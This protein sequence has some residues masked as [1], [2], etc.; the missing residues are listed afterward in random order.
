M[1]VVHCSSPH[2]NQGSRH[3]HDCT[4]W[5]SCG[6]DDES[7]T[8]YRI[9]LWQKAL[10]MPPHADGLSGSRW[11]KVKT[12]PFTHAPSNLCVCWL[13]NF[14]LFAQ[15]LSRAAFMVSRY[16]IWRFLW[17]TLRHVLLSTKKCFECIK[18]SA[19]IQ[20]YIYAKSSMSCGLV[21]SYF[22]RFAFICAFRNLALVPVVGFLFF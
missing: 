18:L 22:V 4:K 2:L 13:G 11:K 3:S 7:I 17:R 20:V 19:L 12:G 10:I 21:C 6:C 5:R 1:G 8:T 9:K 15:W 14:L 16:C